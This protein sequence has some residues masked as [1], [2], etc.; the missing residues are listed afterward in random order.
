M[1]LCSSEELA[2]EAYETN[3][4]KCRVAVDLNWF[5]RDILG[6]ICAPRNFRKEEDFCQNGYVLKNNMAKLVPN[7]D[8]MD[9]LIQILTEFE[10]VYFLIIC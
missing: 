5:F 4:C 3:E 1:L 2:P 10:V 6:Y 7:V 8:Q 9:C